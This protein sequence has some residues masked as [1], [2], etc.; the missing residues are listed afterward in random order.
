MSKTVLLVVLLFALLALAV[1]QQ[2]GPVRKDAEAVPTGA[3]G[4]KLTKPTQNQKRAILQFEEDDG[5]QFIDDDEGEN[6]DLRGAVDDDYF[7]E[8]DDLEIIKDDDDG[9]DDDNMEVSF[10][11]ATADFVYSSTGSTLAAPAA[12]CV[13]VLVAQLF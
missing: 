8:D 3:F 2:K 10:P 7:F 13:L 1:A 11:P 6:D 5:L 9:Y 12:L 4:V